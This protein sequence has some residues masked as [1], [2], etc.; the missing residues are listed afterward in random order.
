MLGG[1]VTMAALPALLFGIAAA[2][3]ER[4]GEVLT[5]LV[6]FAGVFVIAGMAAWR[7]NRL[8][9]IVISTLSACIAFDLILVMV[10]APALRPGVIAANTAIAAILLVPAMVTALDWRSRSRAYEGGSP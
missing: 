3:R 2:T 9:A 1:V 10:R 7:G 8:G 5:Y 4:G 6:W